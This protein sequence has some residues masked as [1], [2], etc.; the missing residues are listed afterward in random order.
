MPVRR[1]RG[2]LVP[3]CLG[4]VT[5][6]EGGRALVWLMNWDSYWF[7]ILSQRYLFLFP[8]KTVL[9]QAGRMQ[10]SESYGRRL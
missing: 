9:C 3:E 1:E 2:D 6:L 10:H 5:G 8:S 4:A 7:C